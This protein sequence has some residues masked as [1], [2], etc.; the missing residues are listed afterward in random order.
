MAPGFYTP[1]SLEGALRLRAALGEEAVFL[2]GGTVVNNLH[3]PRASHLISLA[4]AVSREIVCSDRDVVIG[5]GATIQEIAASPLVPQSLR[6]AALNVA[7]RNIRNI[8]TIGGHLGAN[9]AH[10]DL[11]PVL[12]ALRTVVERVAAAGAEDVSLEVLVSETGPG[13]AVIRAIRL[14][15]SQDRGFGLARQG[16]TWSD[17]ATVS[18]AVSLHV[19]GATCR[20]VILALGGVAAHVVRLYDV[21]AALEG[22]PLPC[23][24]LLE[25]LVSAAVHPGDGPN[26]GATYKK[27][28]AGTLAS[29][30]FARALQFAARTGTG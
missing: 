1:A 2:S 8:A 24:K 3:S 14:P 28:L 20:D 17:F 12:L 15:D 22:A 6:E 7:N 27:L 5:A 10:S 26:Q 19:D 23:H 18:A 21:E 25:T 13:G 30:A 9:V 11:I 29:R 4:N 16:R